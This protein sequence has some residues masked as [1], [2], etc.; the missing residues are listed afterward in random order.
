MPHYDKYNREER[1]I[2]SHLFRLLHENLDLKKNSSLGQFLEILSRTKDGINM[3]DLKFENIG[4]YS[5]V[6]I[7]RDAF[8]NRK[9]NI[10]SFMSKL[11]KIVVVQ[12]GLNGFDIN[13]ILKEIKSTHPSK[14]KQ[15]AD[16]ENKRKVFGTIQGMFN[17]KPD[18]AITIDNKL[19]VIE[20][21]FT[22]A[23]DE[24]Q[25]KRTRN[26]AEVWASLLYEDFGFTKKPEYDVYKLGA[27]KYRP[28]IKWT[29]VLDIARNT[30]RNGDRTLSSIE[31]GVNLLKEINGE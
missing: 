29:E 28:N 22:E 20:A 9:S 25:M 13:Q 8:K 4:I 12:E 3:T 2:C 11:S 26:I 15:R 30:Y 19:I 14:F 21:K 7:I 23:F 31:N 5:E 17:A 1:A 10:D 27:K 24:V 18:L 16:T 6:S